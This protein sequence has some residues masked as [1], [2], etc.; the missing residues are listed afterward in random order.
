MP[1]TPE[2]VPPKEPKQSPAV[3]HGDFI[4]KV[5]LNDAREREEIIKMAEDLGFRR[6]GLPEYT[7]KAHGFEGEHI[8]NTDGISTFLKHAAKSYVHV[9]ELRKSLGFLLAFKSRILVSRDSGNDSN[10]RHKEGPINAA[11]KS[12]SL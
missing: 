10:N 11:N 7:R 9:Q 6:R 12:D 1:N 3:A 8:A 5:Y 2:T 4:V